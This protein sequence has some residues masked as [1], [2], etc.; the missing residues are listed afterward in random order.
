MCIRDSLYALSLKIQD[1][2]T[3][4][5]VGASAGVFSMVGLYISEFMINHETVHNKCVHFLIGLLLLGIH[6][7][8]YVN[9][10]GKVAVTAHL[11]GLVFGMSPALLYIPNYEYEEWEVVLCVLAVLIAV[12]FFVAIPIWLYAS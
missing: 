7:Y 4:T 5:M 3:E 6:G 8:E 11:G 9:L 10:S 2:G 12:F 1:A